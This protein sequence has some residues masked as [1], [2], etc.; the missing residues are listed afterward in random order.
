MVLCARHHSTQRVE[1]GVEE[2]RRS[3]RL[4]NEACLANLFAESRQVFRHIHRVV[5]VL[6]TCWGR[7]GAA[8]SRSDAPRPGESAYTAVGPG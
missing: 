8:A 5:D 7:A 6:W 3:R 4:R 2:G 1:L